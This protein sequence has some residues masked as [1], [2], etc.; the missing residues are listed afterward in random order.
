MC[1]DIA[2]KSAQGISAC[3]ENPTTQ[4]QNLP[5][6]HLISTI[7]ILLCQLELKFARFIFTFTAEEF[8]N[9]AQVL[10]VYLI[11]VLKHTCTIYY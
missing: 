4:I 5:Y 6:L 9:P 11:P 3:L 8:F 1:Y 2:F 10:P 7:M